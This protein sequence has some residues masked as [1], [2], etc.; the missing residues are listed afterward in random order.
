MSDEAVEKAVDD[1]MDDNRP[2]KDKDLSEYHRYTYS[3]FIFIMVCLAITVLVAD[4]RYP[5]G[6][7][8]YHSP[9]HT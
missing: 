7:I 2:N 5:L 1:W 6:N 4:M 3:K 8:P 9:I